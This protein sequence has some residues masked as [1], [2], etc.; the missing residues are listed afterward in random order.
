MLMGFCKFFVLTYFRHYFLLCRYA[1]LNR[2]ALEDADLYARTGRVR[3]SSPTPASNSDRGSSEPST[4]AKAVLG[5]KGHSVGNRSTNLVSEESSLLKFH[6]EIVI[7]S[8]SEHDFC[9]CEQSQELANEFD[10][11]NKEDS[12]VP[13]TS[14]KETVSCSD[15]DFDPSETDL[16]N[17][18][19]NSTTLATSGDSDSKT[20]IR[21]SSNGKRLVCESDVVLQKLPR[22]TSA[23]QTSTPRIKVHK[24]SST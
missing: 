4:E 11:P 24:V 17:G 12:D 20:S 23:T 18:S 5:P 1:E 2:K 6:A 7:S 10:V 14:T 21:T 8:D 15:S 22:M 3:T 16:D 19:G 13:T 9:Q